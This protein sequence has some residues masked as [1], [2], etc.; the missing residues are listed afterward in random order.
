[1]QMLFLG[2]ESNDLSVD[3]LLPWF[4]ASLHK[5][6]PDVLCNTLLNAWN[7]TTMEWGLYAPAITL[8][9]L[10]I[11]KVCA[12]RFAELC[13]L[14][15]PGSHRSPDPLL[16]FLERWR[17]EHPSPT[18]HSRPKPWFCNTAWFPLK[19]FNPSASMLDLF[20]A[21]ANDFSPQAPFVW[22]E[23]EVENGFL[24]V[25][26]DCPSVALAID[27]HLYLHWRWFRRLLSVKGCEEVRTRIIYLP[28][29]VTPNICTAILDSAMGEFH[30]ELTS[31]EACTVLALGGELDLF[32]HEGT[33]YSPFGSLNAY[34]VEMVKKVS[35]DAESKLS[36]TDSSSS[37]RS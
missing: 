11:D 24:F 8:L 27:I 19:P 32:D 23:G 15:P 36:N 37:A 14:L 4:T 13:A 28:S 1:M 16:N 7:D 30:N 12:K 34:C 18:T 20:K 2:H 9:A 5:V 29:W 25:L 6:P 10:Q 17:K 22:S 26:Y 31:E 33:P 3:F 35:T 21:R